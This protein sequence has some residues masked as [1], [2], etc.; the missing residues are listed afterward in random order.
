M[1]LFAATPAFALFKSGDSFNEASEILFGKGT[2]ETLQK[3]PEN[4]LLDVFEGVPLFEVPRAEIDAGINIVD[5]IGASTA[6]VT[7]KGEA[8]R[9]LKEGGIS[10]NKAKVDDQFVVDATSLLNQKYILAQRGKKN[11]YLVKVI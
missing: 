3:L 7:S 8:R 5:F 2:T 10:I 11:F 4:V 9:A 6:V 1:L